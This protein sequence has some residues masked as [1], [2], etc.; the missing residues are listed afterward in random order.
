MT[1]DH[2]QSRRDALENQ[3]FSRVDR[4]LVAGLK[5]RMDRDEREKDLR[6]KT[7]IREPNTLRFLAELDLGPETAVA[8]QLAPLVAV[9]W[10]NGAV[11]PA[12][13]DAVLRAADELG[14]PKDSTAWMTLRSWLD[15]KPGPE[16][17]TA[18]KSFIHAML[19]KAELVTRDQ[20]RDEV[21]LLSEQVADAAGGFLGLAFRTSS[22]EQAVLDDIRKTFDETV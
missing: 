15:R 1:D 12:E 4:E 2:F 5:S 14:L 16:L 19:P 22:Q 13:R 18:W 17:L 20:L 10:A 7:G 11:E 21:L 9:A 3:F 8:L 6:E